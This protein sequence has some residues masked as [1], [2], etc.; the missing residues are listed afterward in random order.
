MNGKE[1]TLTYAPFESS[2]DWCHSAESAGW[3]L[4]TP[5]VLCF[6]FTKDEYQRLSSL[7]RMHNLVVD[8]VR[9]HF[10]DSI[11]RLSS[12]VADATVKD[13]ISPG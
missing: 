1:V 10:R 6:S 9:C 13:I 3:A 11:N 2:P 12:V 5:E 8:V 7:F 4:T